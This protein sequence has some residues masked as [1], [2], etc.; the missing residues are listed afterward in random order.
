MISIS[1]LTGSMTFPPRV[2][3]APV[4]SVARNLLTLELHLV[5][6][7]RCLE[8]VTSQPRKQLWFY[9]LYPLFNGEFRGSGGFSSR[10]PRNARNVRTEGPRRQT[11]LGLPHP[12][13]YFCMQQRRIKLY[14]IGTQLKSWPWLVRK[15]VKRIGV[16]WR[17]WSGDG[18]A[19][20]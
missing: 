9:L 11:D 16:G 6:N 10:L 18:S 14:L 19:S 12:K 20:I 5:E 17:P 15:M 8:I 2:W 4:S 7:C 13:Q 3:D 1:S